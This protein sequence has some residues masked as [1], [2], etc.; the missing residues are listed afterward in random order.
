MSKHKQNKP[1][2]IDEP[3]FSKAKVRNRDELEFVNA[4]LSI[5]VELQN[6]AAGKKFLIK[7]FGCQGNVRDSEFLKG[8]FKLL[9]MTEVE[10][11]SDA[12]IILF[13]TCAIRENAENKL[14]S[15]LGNL[16]KYYLKNRNLI[17][18]VCGCVMQEEE[19]YNYLKKTYPYVK[20]VFG[21]FNINN[22]FKLLTKV[23]KEN[24]R[25][26]EVISKQG[27]IIENMPSVRNDKYKAFVNIMYGC[28]K[29][30]SYC[31]VPFTRGQQRSRKKEDILNEVNELIKQGYKEVTLIGQNV[32][33]Y[34]LDLSKSDKTSFAELLELVS[35][36]NIERVR[37][38]TSHPF[39]FNEK[40][41]EIMAK[42]PNIMPALHLPLQSGSDSV[43]KSMNRKY[44]SKR[45]LELVSLLR[46]HIPDVCLT[47]DIIV[48]FPTET[49]ED[50][51]KT[52]D[53][54]KKVRFDA[55][56]TFIFSPR[57][58]T[59]AAKMENITSKEEI[60]RR[61]MLLKET[62][63]NITCEKSQEY[64][65]K[66]V[67]VLFDC[68]SKKN[69]KMISGYDEHNKLVHVKYQDGL[70]GTIRKVKILESHTFSYI[71]EVIE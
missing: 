31:I 52:L 34:G 10:D 17:V 71:G 16:K 29:F 19:P 11:F 50:F 5:P 55:A 28:D 47:T 38:T 45:Y 54:C 30:C 68:V 59:V 13:N 35:K 60:S 48:G 8:Y 41:F 14:F 64:V 9:N 58:G 40:V 46:K 7:T 21:T 51:N 33:S 6:W 57:E 25:V 66:T 53:L 43:L 44:D 22:I 12:N 3:N 23:I 26:V 61:F 24:A 20:L 2:I 1:I 70:I 36:T 56:Y 42:Y 69:D 62:I 37:F 65:G 18:G 4:D 63:D 32:N 49:L 15:E 67:K 39:D 27:E